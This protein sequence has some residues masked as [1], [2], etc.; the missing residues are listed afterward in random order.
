MAGVE[1]GRD[2]GV[3]N[4]EEKE[5]EDRWVEKV[6]REKKEEMKNEKEGRNK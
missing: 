1:R 2:K 3:K 4:E 5:D 6:G